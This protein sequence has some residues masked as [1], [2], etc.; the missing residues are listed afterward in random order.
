MQRSR[1][2]T[3]V[4]S[5]IV[6]IACTATVACSGGDSGPPTQPPG[7]NQG[8][9]TLSATTPAVTMNVGGSGVATVVIVRGGGFS[10]TVS[11][12]VTGLPA[13]V[14]GTFVPAS[15]DAA[16]TTSLLNLTSVSTAAAGTSTLTISASGTG[17]STQTATVQ[18]ILSQPTIT[19][20]LTPTTLAVQAGLTG[21]TTLS[22]VRSAGF[23]GA[24][25]LTLDNPPAGITG[26][27]NAS[28]TAASS[29]VLTVSVASSVAA[30]PYTLTIKGTAAGAADKTV[31]VA[32]TVTAAGL[33]GFSVSVDPVE[34][35]LPAG[36]GWAAYGI[37]SIQRLNGFTGPVT[38]TV[39]GLSFPAVVAPTP[40]TIV[41]GQTATNLFALAVDNA[42][43]GLYTGTVRVS[44]P[45][46][47]DQAAT[48]RFRVSLPSTG[49]I[50][51]N[52]C[53]ADRTPR[54]FA[55]RDGSGA[56]QH[57]VPDGPAS[58]TTALPSKYSFSIAQSTASV[59]LVWSG[60]KTSA[61]PL[62]EGHHWNVFYLTRQEVIDL[63][64]EECITSRE[65]ST[66]T[67]SGSLTGYQSFDAVVASAGRRAWAFAGS[68]G[69]LTTTLSMQNLPPGPFDLFV[70]RTNF[71]AGPNNPIAVQSF[72]LRRGIDPA[73]GGTIP[74]MSFATE[75]AAPATAALTFANTNG[76]QFG[77]TM[78]FNTADGLVGLASATGFYTLGA[79]TWYGVPTTRLIAGDLHQ[80]IA[81]TT[82]ATA[83]RQIIHYSRDVVARTLTF[84]A[85]LSL[86]TVTS[87]F[88]PPWVLRAAGTLGPDYT[89]RVS[90]YYR[91]TIPDPRTMTIVATR[92]FLGGTTQYDVPIPDLA[93]TT[94][95]TAFWNLRRGAAVRW[96]V[97]GGQGAT[98]DLLTDLFCTNVGY[99]PVKAVDGATYLSA[100]ATGTVTV[101]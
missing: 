91:E 15:L 62:I 3:S 4:T 12:A 67:A 101:P 98:G 65:T 72:V 20:G 60:E 55:I 28:P 40:A 34:F 10:G 17:V 59:A 26:T 27:F 36:R 52:F 44:A 11:L 61:S 53:R 96:T 58:P 25:T 92:G 8:T 95:F 29:S 85:P 42:T 5:T 57:V 88:T 33:V 71:S 13:G 79:R 82:N 94:G 37:A 30:G 19:L 90:V 93:G 77:N 31:T 14:S 56:W 99:C 7:Q 43:P 46:F 83:R 50:T 64:A 80:V 47:A 48:V 86:P 74:A 51:W 73:A 16:S 21:L 22:I 63:A 87:A 68:T 41:A 70:S 9:L 2:S 35:E 97:T 100:Q 84:G 6:A 66:R 54:Y 39:Q 1:F 81:T 32:L 18:L 23:T 78:T 24:V 75:G 76:E 49:N 69:P 89:S 38:V 45:G